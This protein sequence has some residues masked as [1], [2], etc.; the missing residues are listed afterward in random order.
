MTMYEL[1]AAPTPNDGLTSEL[2]ALTALEATP[3]AIRLRIAGLAPDQ[4]YRGT[5]NDLSIAEQVGL[6]TV[7]EQAYLATL[8]RI[9]Q[10]TEPALVEPAPS[11]TLLD[12]DFSADL[13]LFFDLRRDTLNLLRSFSAKAWQVP[14][15]LGGA[16]LPVRDLAVR[17]AEHD[18]Q[19]LHSISRQRQHWTKTSGVDELR[20]YGVAG[21]LGPNLGQ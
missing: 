15:R 16:A 8:Q 6:A 14:V 4:I 18:R 9:G 21:K 10:E 11:P 2:R 13:A 3:N 1:P 19:M 12:R 20:D 5:A 17:L 7:R